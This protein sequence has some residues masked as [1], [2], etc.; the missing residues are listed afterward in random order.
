MLKAAAAQMTTNK[1]KVTVNGE[2]V[3]IPLPKGF[4]LRKQNPDCSA[5]QCLC[6]KMGENL[7]C[8]HITLKTL[9]DGSFEFFE[10]NPCSKNPTKVIEEI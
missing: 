5:K 8:C 7:V 3:E 2:D 6:A 10:M 4:A 1:I 9:K